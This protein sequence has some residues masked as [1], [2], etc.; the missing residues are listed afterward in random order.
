[1]VAKIDDAS[2]DPLGTLKQVYQR[3]STQ[4]SRLGGLRHANVR[5]FQGAGSA[6]ENMRRS[7]SPCCAVCDTQ[8]NM[9]QHYLSVVLVTPVTHSVT[10]ISQTRFARHEDARR[11]REDSSAENP[12]VRSYLMAS[13]ALEGGGV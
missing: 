6:L 5:S 2:A 4:A 7:P 10:T 1:M 3:E 13:N 12:R 9:L 8:Q 11:G